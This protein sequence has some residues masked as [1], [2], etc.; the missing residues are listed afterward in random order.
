M[1][2]GIGAV[3]ERIEEALSG[4]SASDKYRALKFAADAAEASLRAEAAEISKTLHE[5]AKPK[6]RRRTSKKKELAMGGERS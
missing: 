5:V 4:V 2:D 6:R 1:N 3:V